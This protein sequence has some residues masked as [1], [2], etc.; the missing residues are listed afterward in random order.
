MR[1]GGGGG[2]K[3]KRIFLLTLTFL[4]ISFAEWGQLV[5][6]GTDAWVFDIQA[7]NLPAWNNDVICVVYCNGISNDPTW[8]K[9]KIFNQYG[10][11]WVD[12]TIAYV[13]LNRRP[14][15]YKDVQNNQFFIIWEDFSFSSSL[16]E[17]N[18]RYAVVDLSGDITVRWLTTSDTLFYMLGDFSYF[19]T[20]YSAPYYIVYW[21]GRNIAG[22]DC[23][24]INLARISSNGSVVDIDTIYDRVGIVRD[25]VAVYNPDEDA[26]YVVYKRKEPS[27]YD[28]DIYATKV[29]PEGS[30]LWPELTPVCVRDGNQDWESDIEVMPITWV[31]SEDPDG[32]IV[33]GYV[34]EDR[35]DS[36][37]L[38]KL[39]SNGDQQ[40]GNY[41]YA[42]FPVDDD[43]FYLFTI[44][45]LQDS[46]WYVLLSYNEN[47]HPQ[48]HILKKTP[49][50]DYG[51]IWPNFGY[52]AKRIGRGW[53]GYGIYFYN[54]STNEANGIELDYYWGPDFD[55]L[56][57]LPYPYY[58][59]YLR[60]IEAFETW[61]GAVAFL[62]D[63][64]VWVIPL[65]WATGIYENPTYSVSDGIVYNFLDSK[66][67][68]I[69]DR[70]SPVKIEFFDPSGRIVN[71]Y[72]NM[73]KKGLNIVP[74]E[75]L[76]GKGLYFYKI[77][78]NGKVLKGKILKIKE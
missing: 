27:S 5:Y 61:Y 77:N 58:G 47:G 29:T 40:W 52:Y 51:Y 31:S 73:L 30:P 46:P 19:N 56:G 67:I 44:P 35:D 54:S 1:R 60:L 38:Q 25:P 9:V 17:C 37:Y 14:I 55:Y 68:L 63:G 16:D 10:S 71:K 69:L 70:S 28:Y 2:E 49:W 4:G 13:H 42:M 39:D 20:Y 24:M 64:Y 26:I 75:Y 74:I 45:N 11:I 33:V 32:G 57:T 8:L 78:L 50:N 41:G 7:I 76:G 6:L 3:M 43:E 21:T 34:D 65:E 23:G 15:I 62:K 12:D 66:L 53:H 48:A 59:G 18:I 36:L 72:Q 22:I